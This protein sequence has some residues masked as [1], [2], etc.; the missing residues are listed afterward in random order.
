MTPS[1]SGA[2][3]MVVLIAGAAERALSRGEEAPPTR[4]PAVIDLVVA[5]VALTEAGFAIVTEPACGTLWASRTLCLLLA[6]VVA[7]RGSRSPPLSDGRV[8]P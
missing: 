1:V 5:G 8:S 2:V 7:V 6:G 3:V 4:L